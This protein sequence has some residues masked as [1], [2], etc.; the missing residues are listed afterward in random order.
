MTIGWCSAFPAREASPSLIP[1]KERAIPPRFKTRGIL[2]R[3]R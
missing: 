2:A 1:K 3:F